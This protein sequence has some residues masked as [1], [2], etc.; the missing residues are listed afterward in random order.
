MEIKG[1]LS[2]SL[3]K[4]II[5]NTL[6]APGQ[7]KGDLDIESSFALDANSNPLVLPI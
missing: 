2:Q 5:E 1:S 4:G 7:K 6:I 3:I